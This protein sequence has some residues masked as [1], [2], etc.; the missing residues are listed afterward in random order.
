MC[1]ITILLLLIIIRGNLLWK[2]LDITQYYINVT[3][4]EKSLL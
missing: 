3:V 4:K 1:K 2:N